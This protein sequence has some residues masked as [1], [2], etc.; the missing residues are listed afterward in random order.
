MEISKRFQECFNN[1]SMQIGLIHITLD[2]CARIL[3]S[4]SSMLSSKQRRMQAVP[5]IMMIMLMMMKEATRIRIRSLSSSSGSLSK[6]IHPFFMLKGKGI[7]AKLNSNFNFNSFGFSITFALSDH[8][9][10]QPPGI[11]VE[12]Q[13]Q[14]H[15]QFSILTS[16]LT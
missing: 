13:F 10:V 12:L 5:P 11:V 1:V 6:R 14:P 8:P 16:S 7:I 15:I 3:V 9:P 4:F 2:S